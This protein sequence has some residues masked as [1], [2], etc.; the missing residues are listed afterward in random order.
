MLQ[1]V[2]VRFEVVEAPGEAL[3]GVE[4]AVTAV[5]QMVVGRHEHQARIG[6][7]AAEHAGEHGEI[8]LLV[9]R[10]RRGQPRGDRGAVENGESGVHVCR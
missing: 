5:H 6:D 1:P 9:R 10:G 8:M 3:G 7:D 2:Q 4:D